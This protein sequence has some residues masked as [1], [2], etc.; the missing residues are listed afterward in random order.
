M[1]VCVS[2]KH[3]NFFKQ[4]DRKPFSLEFVKKACEELDNLSNV[5][6]Q[7]GVTVR[8]PVKLSNE[9]K[10]FE[11]PDFSSSSMQIAIPRDLLLVIGDEIIEAPMAWRSRFFEYRLYRPL[12]K[13]YFDKGAKWTTAPKP[14]MS[15]DLYDL[16]YAEKRERERHSLTLEKKR[17]M[18]T[19]HEPCF[20]AADFWKAGSDIFAQRSQVPFNHITVSTMH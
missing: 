18:T 14:L 17:F 13:E 2:E 9:G 16:E 20:D 3:L 12:L 8:R 5:L 11:T 6:K 7:E 19:E 4:N 1:K 10:I 15:D